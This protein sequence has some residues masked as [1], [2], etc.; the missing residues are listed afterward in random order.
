MGSSKTFVENC[1]SSTHPSCFCHNY[2]LCLSHK[3]VKH[4]QSASMQP[5]A[6]MKGFSE[7]HDFLS[8]V[9]FSYRQ[10]VCFMGLLFILSGSL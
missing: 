4:F 1:D 2:Q 3:N 10:T 5:M 6:Q 9:A 7:L 8:S